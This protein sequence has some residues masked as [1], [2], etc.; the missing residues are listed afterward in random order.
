MKTPWIRDC[1]SFDVKRS[2]DYTAVD[3]IEQLV[4]LLDSWAM[5]QHKYESHNGIYGVPENA[6]ISEDLFEELQDSFDDLSAQDECFDL[7]GASMVFLGV[8]LFVE[9]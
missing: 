7:H 6:L 9:K 8:P 4:Y 2:V 5:I 3:S 1:C